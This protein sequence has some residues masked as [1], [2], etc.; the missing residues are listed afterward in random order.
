MSLSI[1]CG[2]FGRCTFTATR[3]PFGSTARCTWP[4][5]AAAIGSLVELEEEPL[6]R[7]AELLA[8]H[9]L[10]VGERERAHVVLEAAQ[11]GDD[12]RRDD[13]GPRREQLAE[14]D[15]RRPELVEHLAQ[16]APARRRRPSAIG[17]RRAGPR[18]GSRSRAAP[19]PG[20]S[21]RAGRCCA[22]FDRADPPVL[23]DAGE[24]RLL[25]PD[26]D[27][28]NAPGTPPSTGITQPVVARERSET[29]NATAS[30]TSR[31]G[32]RRGRAG[33][34]TRRSASSSSTRDAVRLG[35]LARAARPTRAASRRRSRRG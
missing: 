9:A 32:H 29:R 13:V 4:I 17:R 21:R 33:C 7:L 34:A 27:A 31:A 35:A 1:C 5:D 8:D 3:R 18:S 25:V 2:A 24:R 14:L 12:V 10:D 15:E 19:R 23:L 26:L 6:D 16:V 20:R 22:V 28:G 30:A 11:L